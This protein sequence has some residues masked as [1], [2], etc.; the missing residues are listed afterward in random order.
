MA[1]G[2]VQDLR[3]RAG[4][5]RLAR[6]GRPDHEDVALLDLHLGVRVGRPR[7][8]P[9]SGDGAGGSWRMRL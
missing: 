2:H 5:Q 3:Q 7:F 6:A 1:K 8:F 9:S 4:Q